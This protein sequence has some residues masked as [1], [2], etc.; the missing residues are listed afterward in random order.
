MSKI[1]TFSTSFQTKHPRKGEPTFFVEKIFSGLAEN[2]PDWRMPKDFTKYDWHTYYNNRRHKIHTIRQGSRFKAGEKFSPRIWSEKPYMSKQIIFSE[3][4]TITHIDRFE[5]NRYH[6]ILNYER[7][8]FDD[9][10]LITIAAND[11]LNVQDFVAWFKKP[12]IG[13]IIHWTDYKY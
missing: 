1:I 5:F 9:E 10:R 3:D 12:F 7:I 8:E 11:G 6:F 2:F 13:Q 4:L